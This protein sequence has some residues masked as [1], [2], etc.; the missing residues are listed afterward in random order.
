MKYS[1]G[2]LFNP[3]ETKVV[4]IKKNRHDWEKGL[5]NGVGG[6]KHASGFSLSLFDERNK[7]ICL[8]G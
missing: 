2:F 1:V 3:D 7:G 8:G 5:L 6:H 4:L